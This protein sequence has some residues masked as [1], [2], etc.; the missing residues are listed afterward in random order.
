MLTQQTRLLQVADMGALSAL[1]PTG[2]KIRLFT[3]PLINADPLPISAFTEAAFTGYSAVAIALTQQGVA[4]TGQAVLKLLHQAVF[5]V[6]TAGATEV[7]QGWFATDTGG[8]ALLAYGFFDSPINMTNVGDSILL[9]GFLN[10][11]FTA[12]ADVEVITGP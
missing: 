11:T 6:S 5:T 4:P 7:I 3:A 8:T 12:D 9:N 1:F 2:S 10:A